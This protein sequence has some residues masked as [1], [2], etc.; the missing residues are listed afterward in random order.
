[1]TSIVL[2]CPAAEAEAV[3]AAIAELGGGD[4]NLSIQL[5]DVDGN[6]WLGGHSSS[7][8]DFLPAITEQFPS[9]VVST[10]D[11]GG[12]SHWVAALAA[13]NLSM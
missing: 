5:Q 10:E 1:M 4:S 8:L 13:N 3:N 7:E 11:S 2:L 9:L 12:Y 6:P